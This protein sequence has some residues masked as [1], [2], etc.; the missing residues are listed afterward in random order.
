MASFVFVHI[1]GIFGMIAMDVKVKKFFQRTESALKFLET[2]EIRPGVPDLIII[3]GL[4]IRE[5][6]EN[7][8]VLAI[9]R[10]ERLPPKERLSIFAYHLKSIAKLHPDEN[11]NND[12]CNKPNLLRLSF[13][14]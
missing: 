1:F 10:T 6:S 4:G 13:I 9:P 7:I 12:A 2:K 3:M 8:E 14:S 11:P 5:I